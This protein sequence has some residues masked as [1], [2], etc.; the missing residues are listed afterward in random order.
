MDSLRDFC[1]KAA[2]LLCAASST[3]S[4]AAETVGMQGG[5]QT[6]IIPEPILLAIIGAS[7]LAIGL[8]MRY[9]ARKVQRRGDS[10]DPAK[11]EH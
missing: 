4:Q 3:T 1:T 7:L 8:L 10:K 11:P 5:K 6:A 9:K 2:A